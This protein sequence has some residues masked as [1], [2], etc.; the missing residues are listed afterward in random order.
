MKSK[1]PAVARSILGIK[2]RDQVYLRNTYKEKLNAT[3]ILLEPMDL[4]LLSDPQIGLNDFPARMTSVAIDADNNLDS[5]FEP[6][7]Y[8]VHAPQPVTVTDA[9]PFRPNYGADPGDVNT[10]IIFEGVPQLNQAS[11]Q[12]ELWIVLSSPSA[13][14]TAERSSTFRPTAARVTRHSKRGRRRVTRSPDTQRAIGRSMRTRI[15]QTIC[16]STSLN[17]TE[18]SRA[19]QSPRRTLSD[20]CAMWRPGRLAS[21]T[22]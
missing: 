12:E 16:P 14:N 21:L 15:R 9:A 10:P 19:I 2:V 4:V 22:N 13:G 7:V 17:R 3:R 5:E 20:S 6:F 1:S 18:N 11:N 8:A